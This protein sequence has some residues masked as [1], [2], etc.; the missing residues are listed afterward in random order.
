MPLTRS[1]KN[2]PD[3]KQRELRFLVGKLL[4]YKKTKIHFIILFG[5]FARG[6]WVDDTYTE[7]DGTTYS[8]KS[9]FDLLVILDPC[10][11]PKQRRQELDLL[12]IVREQLPKITT[13]TSLIAHDITSINR[14][15]Q[16]REY[17]FADI[18]R[19]GIVLFDSGEYKLEKLKPLT[20][21]DR[22]V[23]A[24]ED[25]EYWFNK[26][27]GFYEVFNFCVKNKEYSLAA[28]NLHQ[29]TECLYDA[30]LLV[31]THY[32]PKIHD[33]EKLRIMANSLDNRLLKTFPITNEREEKLF[34]LLRSAYID[35]RYKKSYHITKPQLKYLQKRVELLQ[36]VCQE[37]CQEKIKQFKLKVP[38]KGK[39]LK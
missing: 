15:L 18:K 24:V 16:K 3:R 19:E 13:H 9:D 6:D 35:A 20:A 33:L 25:F 17:F 12:K 5:S 23:C 22:Y 38:S 14:F 37:I 30:I 7:E 39:V 36:K 31:Y 34:E 27:K 11:M 2:L 28:F 26:A 29:V 4:E 21:Q 8:Y 32:K 1:L 10:S